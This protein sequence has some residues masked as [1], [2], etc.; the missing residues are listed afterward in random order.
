MLEPMKKH[1]I[2][3]TFYGPETHKHLAV[4]L[5]QTI[6]FELIES[7]TP[8]SI[9]SRVVLAEFSNNVPGICLKA[10]R[11]KENLTQQQLSERADIPRRYISEMETG[12]RFI[13]ENNARSFARALNVGYKVFLKHLA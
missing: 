8:D 11:E 10:A 3:L 13:G 5:L 6:D 12:K 1:H 4:K 9:P 7:N 2:N